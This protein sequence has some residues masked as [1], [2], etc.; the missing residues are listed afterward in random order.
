M[1]LESKPEEFTKQ[2]RDTLLQVSKRRGKNRTD[3]IQEIATQIGR[4]ISQQEYEI[5]KLK[6]KL[7]LCDSDVVSKLVAD[8]KKLEEAAAYDKKWK[9]RYKK[10][11]ETQAAE[12]DDLKKKLGI[13]EVPWYEQHLNDP[14]PELN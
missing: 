14:K 3:L 9:A 2:V 4:Y 11:H 1:N 12:I 10:Y 8:K 7:I 13:P 6:N 5:T